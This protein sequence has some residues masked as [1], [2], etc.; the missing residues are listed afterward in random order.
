MSESQLNQRGVDE[1]REQHT[2]SH[3]STVGTPA[4]KACCVCGTDLSGRTRF[5]DSQ[6]R[7]WCPTC[8]EKDQLA[9]EPAACPDCNA[10][11]TR[12]DL[13]EF[14]GVPVCKECWEKR[15]QV[16]RREEARI[17]RAE[18][19]AREDAERRRRWFTLG[20]V[21]AVVVVLWGVGTVIWFLMK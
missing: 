1:A 21:A 16:A 19:A 17:Q 6:G 12:A 3:D 11:M 8:N 15:R 13:V 4:G 14:K 2:S 7:Y 10:Q 9:K 5:K 18:E 20:I